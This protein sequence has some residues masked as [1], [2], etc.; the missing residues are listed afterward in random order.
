MTFGTIVRIAAIALGIMSAVILARDGFNIALHEYLDA[1]I[2]VYDDAFKDIALIVFE[3]LIAAVF[4][5]FRDWFDWHLQL[6][7]HWKYCFTL[8]WL[9]LAAC[10]RTEAPKNKLWSNL[11]GGCLALL[12]GVSS[13][14]VPVTH[15]GVFLSPVLGTAVYWLAADFPTQ[16]RVAGVG[17]FL[18]GLPYGFAVWFRRVG[19]FALLSLPVGH[20]GLS[21]ENSWLAS[22][23][24]FVAILAAF[25]IWVTLWVSV[26]NRRLDFF[27]DPDADTGVDIFAVLGGAAAIVYVAH[28]PA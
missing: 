22:L 15:W 9:Y 27:G 13:G 3:P 28:L 23:V 2:Q 7:G 18:E 26:R 4:T 16:V 25:H 8:T 17:G 10:A 12:V 14:V 19:A 24:A 1:V 11:W 6:Y 5:L 21:S 20:L